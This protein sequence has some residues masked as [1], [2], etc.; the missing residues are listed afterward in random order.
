[1][2]PTFQTTALRR[3]NS[4]VSRF[5]GAPGWSIVLL[6][7]AVVGIPKLLT[8][9]GVELGEWLVAVAV[10]IV[11]AIVL[12]VRTWRLTRGDDDG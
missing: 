9:W 12:A 7:A 1:M 11:G 3:V 8:W 2:R 10:L 5:F 4:A 6:A